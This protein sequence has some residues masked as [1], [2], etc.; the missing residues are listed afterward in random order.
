MG[1]TAPEQA[2]VAACKAGEPCKLGDGARPEGPDPARTVRAEVL[3]F[4][5]LG[6][7]EG[8][9]VH[10]LGVWLAGAYVRGELDLSFA[11][12]RGQTVLDR[13]RF[14]ERPDLQQ[15]D[16]QLLSLD[17]SA[18]PGLFAE[19]AQVAGD[20]FLRDGFAA[21]GEVRLS[22]ATVGGQLAC[23]G[24]AFRNPGGKALSAQRMRVV[25]SFF[26]R[27]V[28]VHEGVIDLASAHVG[29]L[30]DD[31]DSWPEAGRLILDG[32]TYDRIVAAFTDSR[33]RLDWLA[34]GTVWKGEF[35]P[36]PYTHLARVL[37]EMGHERGARD[38]LEERDRLIGVHARGRLRARTVAAGSRA[39]Q[40]LGTETGPMQAGAL[41]V[42]D[43]VV[44]RVVGYGHK[45]FRSLGWLLFLWLLAVWLAHMAWVS[46]AM[47]PNSDVILTSGGWQA[48]LGAAN[49][50]A[51]WSAPGGAGQDWETF[52]RYAWAFDV[53][54]PILSLGQTEAWAPSTARGGW[55]WALW[56]GR[57]VL[58]VAGWIVVALAAA[59]VT[60]I[61]R[62]D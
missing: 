47:V 61:I 25:A 28:Q 50:A 19:G 11:R 1:L 5:I 18:L 36:Q 22:G 37:R 51:A 48:V 24:G 6:G 29:D 46:R 14:G 32:F 52:S 31:P 44:R 21:E 30:A 16:L 10:E 45:P 41:A 43:W 62:R 12:A 7:D 13:C 33:E 17:G 2:L 9:R 53:V 49:P 3:R 4:L 58:T 56:W 55:G 27:G 39:D 26:F 15:A 8:C 35:K 38:V 34:K 42:W 59:A 40:L 20:V 60:G 57:W 54:V 23:T